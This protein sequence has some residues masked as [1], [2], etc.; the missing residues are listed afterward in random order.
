MEYLIQHKDN[1]YLTEKS[2]ITEDI[3]KAARFGSLKTA[4]NF[5][6]N[7]LPK[8][9]MSIKKEFNI[10]KIE[11]VGPDNF[12]NKKISENVEKPKP[13]KEFQD[14]LKEYYIENNESIKTLQTDIDRLNEDLNNLVESK[15]F[16]MNQLSEIDKRISKIYHFI[17]LHDIEPD[18]AVEIVLILKDTLI[19]R[20]KIKHS[21]QLIASIET[22]K[23][24]SIKN[25]SST[26]D[27]LA[28]NLY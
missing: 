28:K 12:K 3:G 23:S 27:K 18:I 15:E 21:L 20:R 6:A 16:L 9:L 1:S 11:T 13:T 24:K 19:K 26:I 8:D 5:I 10:V 4:K 22:D 2:T 14:K 7:N 17:E 25:L